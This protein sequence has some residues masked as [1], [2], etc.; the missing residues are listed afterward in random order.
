VL[1]S[2]AR[3]VPLPSDE[4]LRLAAASLISDSIDVVR[5]MGQHGEQHSVD[6][7]VGERVE[8]NEGRR[9]G[10]SVSVLP[11]VRKLYFVNDLME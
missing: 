1:A 3:D 7:G 4:R 2:N 5:E 6:E 9:G 11:N 8:R 10:F